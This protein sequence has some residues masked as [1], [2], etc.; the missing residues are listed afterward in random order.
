MGGG[1]RGKGGRV[2]AIRFRVGSDEMVLFEVPEVREFLRATLREAEC[3][4]VEAVLAGAR[5]AEIARRRG[6]SARTVAHQI[7]AAF[8][9]LGVGSR[10]ELAAQL[11]PLAPTAPRPRRDCADPIA[12]VE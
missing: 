6:T 12:V 8:K 4:I 11:L 5:N 7:A 9:K 3:A 2:E 1:D 10:A